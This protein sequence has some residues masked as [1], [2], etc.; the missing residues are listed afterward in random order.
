MFKPILERIIIR[1]LTNVHCESFAS[2]VRFG[3][4]ERETVPSLF[5]LGLGR[6]FGNWLVSGPQVAGW[7]EGGVHFSGIACMCILVLPGKLSIKDFATTF[8]TKIT[9]IC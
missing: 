2:G 4:T 6:F 9:C 7:R 5:F 3:D 8:P 1:K